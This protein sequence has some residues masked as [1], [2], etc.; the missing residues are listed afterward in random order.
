MS[1]ESSSRACDALLLQ[2][3]GMGLGGSG[4]GSGLGL[5]ISARGD[6]ECV[7]RGGSPAASNKS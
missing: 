7:S 2:P 3:G 1:T 5:G 4:S 6:V